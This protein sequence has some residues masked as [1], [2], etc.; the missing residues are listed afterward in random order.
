MKKED[1][2][3]L[4]T[5]GWYAFLEGE[6]PGYPETVLRGDFGTIRRK[7]Q[8]MRQDETTPDT[9]LADDPMRYNPAVV[10]H[11]VQLMLGGQPPGHAGRVLHC[12]LRYFDPI[13]RRAGVPPDV[14][15]LV[16]RL[17]ADEVR[18]TLVNVSQIEARAVVVQAGGY[19]EHQFTRIAIDGRELPVDSSSF[20]VR[21]APGSGGRLVIRMKRYANQPTLAF[22]WER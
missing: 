18:V 19:A 3:R 21:L 6:S 2:T 15:A 20:T 12:R 1:R 7:V 11:L 5:G 10:T 9:R 17:T 16:D 14:A 8:E 4:P 13:G 22:P